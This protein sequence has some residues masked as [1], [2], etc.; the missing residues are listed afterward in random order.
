MSESRFGKIFPNFLK[1]SIEILR[2]RFHHGTLG[3]GQV[4]ATDAQ[5]EVPTG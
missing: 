2:Q 1:M 5:C 3:F 4:R